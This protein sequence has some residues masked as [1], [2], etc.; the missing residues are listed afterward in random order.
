MMLKKKKKSGS[1]GKYLEISIFKEKY[2]EKLF[3]ENPL[4]IS[5]NFFH[6]LFFRTFQASFFL[7]ENKLAFISGGALG[8]KPPPLAVASVKNSIFI[9][10]PYMF[11][12]ETLKARL[13]T[14]IYRLC[15]LAVMLYKAKGTYIYTVTKLYEGHYICTVGVSVHTHL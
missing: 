5:Q 14:I 12:R 1:K 7:E 3:D 10:A 2:W 11:L 15:Y 13:Q 8:S 9:H 4:K 6:I